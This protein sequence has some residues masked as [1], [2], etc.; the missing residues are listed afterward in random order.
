MNK[1]RIGL[2]AAG[3]I[4][5][6]TF[7][8][9]HRRTNVAL[10][11]ENEWLRQ[12]TNQ[13]ASLRNENQQLSNQ[14][15]QAASPLA[16]DQLS[17]LLRLRGEVI[18]LRRQSNELANLKEQNG[19][20]RT[21]SAGTATARP[22]VQSYT[23]LPKESW[24]F[25]GYDTPEATLQS[26]WWS[27]SRGDT[28]TFLASLTPDRLKQIQAADISENQFEG[29]LKEE[30]SKIKGFQIVKATNL[31][32]DQMVL[33]VSFDGEVRQVKLERIQG[34]WKLAAPITH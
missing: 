34:L 6:A 18:R 20:S 16:G 2:A 25:V 33:D 11:T 27:V 30:A 22:D 3:V 28:Q 12:Q 23:Y 26:V 29:G 13:M 4:A 5:L 8:A 31:A 21:G 19:L 9:V 17:D 10:Q 15:R 24:A 14:V 7:L 1:L 32:D